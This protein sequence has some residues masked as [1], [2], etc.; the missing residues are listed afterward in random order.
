MSLAQQVEAALKAHR[1]NPEE[2]LESIT[3]AV[4]DH[5]QQSDFE[6]SSDS[7]SEYYVTP[8]PWEYASKISGFSATKIDEAPFYKFVE[9]PDSH[10]RSVIYDLAAL[11]CY[12]LTG[13]S[14]ISEY[15]DSRGGDYDA[16]LDMRASLRNTIAEGCSFESSAAYTALAHKMYHLMAADNI[17]TKTKEEFMKELPLSRAIRNEVADISTAYSG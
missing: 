8:A 16:L 4:N 3:K 5:K 10:K 9:A 15:Y 17:Y 11:I 2:L 13:C 6:D 1:D 12:Q 14:H 7:E